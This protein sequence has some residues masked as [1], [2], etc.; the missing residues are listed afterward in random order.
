MTP[1]IVPQDNLPPELQTQAPTNQPAPSQS[2]ASNI[3]P[4]DMLPPEI[5]QSTSEKPAAENAKLGP[6]ASAIVRPLVKGTIGAMYFLSDQLVNAYNLVAGH[7]DPTSI[8]SAITHVPGMPKYIEPATPQL[9]RMLDKYTTKP[10]NALGKIMEEVNSVAATSGGSL[11]LDAVKATPRV[12]NKIV[13]RSAELAQQHGIAI[14]PSYIGGPVSK[15]M[16]S[17]AGKARVDRTFAEKNEAA[18]D[19]LAKRDIGL[20]EHASLDEETIDELRDHHNLAYRKLASLGA[21]KADTKYVKDV[22]AAG[23]RFSTRP[24][25]FGGQARFPAIAQEKDA[26]LVNEFTADHAITAVRQLRQLSRA[27]LRNY[28]VDKNAL[29]YA[30]RQIANA[31]EDQME[32][33][34]VASGKPEIMNAVRNA[35]VQLA[36]IANVEDSLGAGGHVNASQLVRMLD[37]GAPLDGDLLTIARVARDFPEATRFVAAKG[38]EGPWSRIDFLLGGTG[39]L[40]GHLGPAALVATR[41]LVGKALMS[42]PVQRS[43]VRSLTK[44][45]ASLSDAAKYITPSIIMNTGSLGTIDP[46]DNSAP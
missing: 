44:Q 9:E 21:I 32:R 24:T 25:S 27:N 42:G 35:R 16:Q 23:D 8:L 34:A 28:D 1:Q 45:D 43:M 39:I 12:I 22:L 2:P 46:P 38:T 14:P 31:I 20:N 4:L 36:K 5:T 15:T 6:E 37:K 18:I 17:W 30:Q 40:E 41:P 33:V 13:S 3:V 26:Y 19:R 10:D 7:E 29:G 11:A